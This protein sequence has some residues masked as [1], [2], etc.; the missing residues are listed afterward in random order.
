MMEILHIP[1]FG[2]L[3]QDYAVMYWRRLSSL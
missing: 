3:Q 1:N 2:I